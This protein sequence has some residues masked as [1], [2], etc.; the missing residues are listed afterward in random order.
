MENSGGLPFKHGHPKV[1][2]RRKGTKN[3][4]TTDFIAALGADFRK[5]GQSAIAAIREEYPSDYAK[6]IAT[7]VI[8]WGVQGDAQG[9]GT[10]TLNVITG[11]PEGGEVG[12]QRAVMPWSPISFRMAPMSLKNMAFPR[13]RRW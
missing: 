4:L 9:D 7:L 13:A 8:K 3:Q 5:H 1:G 2:G 6:L 10:V 12:P 11:T